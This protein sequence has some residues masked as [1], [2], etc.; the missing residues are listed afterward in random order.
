MCAVQEYGRRSAVCHGDSGG[1]VLHASGIVGV[2]SMAPTEPNCQMGDVGAHFSYFDYMVPISSNLD[3][4]S[5]IIA[6]M[7]LSNVTL[8]E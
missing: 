1:P 4:I 3:W 2:T 7:V 8:V 5:D 6:E